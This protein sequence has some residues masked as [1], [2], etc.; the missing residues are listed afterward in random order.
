MMKHA[1]QVTLAVRDLPAA[2]AAAIVASRGDRV[3]TGFGRTRGG[4]GRPLT[5]AAY[6]VGRAAALVVGAAERDVV[7]GGPSCGLHSWTAI[8][9]V[10]GLKLRAAA[11]VK[12]EREER[13]HNA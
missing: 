3:G 2:E 6:D 4:R 8:P 12:S 9:F 11:A 7:A 1:D 5:G 10:S 13:C